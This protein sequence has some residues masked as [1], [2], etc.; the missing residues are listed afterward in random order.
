MSGFKVDVDQMYRS[1][2][3]SK[4]KPSSQQYRNELIDGVFKWAGKEAYGHYK[5][6]FKELGDLKRKNSSAAAAMSMEI[7]K[8]GDE[9]NPQVQ[10]ALDGFKKEYDKGARM[11]KLGIGGKRK[12]KGQEMMDN[13]MMKMAKMNEHLGVLK[14]ARETEQKRS[15]M[16]NGDIADPGDGSIQGYNSGSHSDE[17]AYS[18]MLANGTLL[19]Y[20][21]VDPSTGE[22]RLVELEGTGEFSE[23]DPDVDRNL[24]MPESEKAEESEIMGL[25]YT[26]L[27]DITFAPPSD[28][29]LQSIQTEIFNTTYNDGLGGKNGETR[30]PLTEDTIRAKVNGVGDNAIKDYFFGGTYVDGTLSKLPESSMA[31]QYL[32][33]LG[34]EPGSQEWIG[35]M[36]I[37]KSENFA[38][39]SP[40]R[41]DVTQ[42]LLQKSND[43]YDN[44]YAKYLSQ[45][46]S[47]KSEAN[48]Y[49]PNK[50]NYYGKVGGHLTNSQVLSEIEK[51]KEGFKGELASN[52]GY[53]FYTFEDGEYYYTSRLEDPPKKTKVSQN[54]VIQG[55]GYGNLGKGDTNINEEEQEFEDFNP[56]K[57]TF[58]VPGDNDGDGIPNEIDPNP[59]QKN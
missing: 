42:F 58:V 16:M 3:G 47:D 46:E 31:Y 45:K 4:Y 33:D 12:N 28:N 10:A 21:E 25:V 38:K 27:Q 40:M 17:M 5:T 36:E 8:I 35:G 51:I 29:S 57:S 37:L 23:G 13:A 52:N 30:N 6:V 11:L 9:L 19:N 14:T 26:P 56:N 7:E 49:D 39:N 18:T 2:F 55:Q 44:G 50:T 34:Y 1:G 32:M 54:D 48:K 53:G 41:E 59:F 20:M 22:L 15:R 43:F 24:I